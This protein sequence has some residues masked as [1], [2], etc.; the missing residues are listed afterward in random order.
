MIEWQDFLD[1]LWSAIVLLACVLVAWGVADWI[2][3]VWQAMGL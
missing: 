1:T 2:W 3:L